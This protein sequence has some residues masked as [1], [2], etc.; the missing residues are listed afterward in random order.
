MNGL[1]VHAACI[2]LIM[3]NDPVLINNHIEMWMLLQPHW[4][5]G[6]INVNNWHSDIQINVSWIECV[7]FWIRHK[8][9]FFYLLM[10]VKLNFI[11]IITILPIRG[12]PCKRW[13]NQFSTI[14]MHNYRFLIFMDFGQT[15]AIFK[16]PVFNFRQKSEGKGYNIWRVF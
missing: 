5:L 3:W 14:T 15:G 1:S 7:A 10:A 6:Q 11:T 13:L 16:L 12:F 2:K 8:T 9:V 4:E